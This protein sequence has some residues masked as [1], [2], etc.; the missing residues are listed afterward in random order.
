MN[1]TV[2]IMA[3]PDTYD[4]LKEW[5]DNRSIEYKMMIDDLQGEIEKSSPRDSYKAFEGDIEENFEE[6]VDWVDSRKPP[7]LFA[8]YHRYSTIET[9]LL[10]VLKRNPKVKVGTFARTTEGRSIYLLRVSTDYDAKKP[11]IFMDAGHH[12]REVSK[13]GSHVNELK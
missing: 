13:K 4:L 8:S 3:S 11:V 7:K 9:V 6:D 2:D 10:R 1:Q 12:A 5:L